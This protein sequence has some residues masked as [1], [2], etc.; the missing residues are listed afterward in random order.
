MATRSAAQVTR[1]PRSAAQFSWTWHDPDGGEPT[2]SATRIEKF[3]REFRQS[4][5]IAAT[6]CTASSCAS[7]VDRLQATSGNELDQLVQ[8]VS[9]SNASGDTS[10]HSAI[11]ARASSSASR[12]PVAVTG[13]HGSVSTRQRPSSA[14]VTRYA[15]RSPRAI[16]RRLA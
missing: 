7:L 1:V 14:A 4:L 8:S 5:E 6:A 15:G 13:T 10:S 2:I 12:R 9:T 3:E 11:A 16:I